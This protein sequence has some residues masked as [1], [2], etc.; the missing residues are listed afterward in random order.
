MYYQS[1]GLKLYYE[2]FGSGKPLILLHGN[3]EDHTIFDKAAEVLSPRYTCCLLDSRGHGKSDKVRELHYQ[4][5]ADDVIAFLEQ[6]DFREAAVYGFSDGGII[7]LLAAMRSDRI[8]R[9]ITSGANCTPDGI[10]PWLHRGFA[11]MNFLR[12]DPLLKLMLEEPNITAEDLGKISCRTL[13]LAGSEDL[14]LPEETKMIADSIP[15][16]ELR[17]LASEG[18]GSYIKHCRKIGDILFAWL[19]RTDV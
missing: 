11:I 16:S 14:V 1:S 13:V 7:G 8:S 12:N 2:M 10:V 15:R 17:I 5:M 19:S 3:G 9:L 18:H 4:D 6:M